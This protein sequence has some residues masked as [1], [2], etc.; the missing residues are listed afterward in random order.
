MD[1]KSQCL[2]SGSSYLDLDDVLAGIAFQRDD[3][4]GNLQHLRIL[5]GAPHADDD[6]AIL[7]APNPIEKLR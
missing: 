7:M 4:G 6:V 2:K 1:G 3:H 5:A